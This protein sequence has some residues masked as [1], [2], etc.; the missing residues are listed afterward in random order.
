[1][2]RPI[3]DR[4]VMAT[5]L[6]P[7]WDQ[8]VGCGGELRKLGC[9]GVI[10][11]YVITPNFFGGSG[12]T[13]LP[14]A[15]SRLA[16]QRRVLE[17]KGLEVIIETPIGLPG[18][19]VNGVAQKYGAS[20]IIIGSHG[21]SRWREGVL[22]TFSSAVLHNVRFPLLILP[23]RVVEGHEPS[24]LWES[25]AL[26]SHLLFPTDFSQTAAEAMCYLE[27][28]APRG[29]SRVTLLHALM[30]TPGQ[31]GGAH[32]DAEA[33]AMARNFLDLLQGRLEAAGVPQV[34]TRV[35]V[36]HPVA[37]IV[38]LLKTMDISLIVL[39]TQ[40]KGF[41]AEIS[42]GSVAHNISRFAPCPLLLIPP[43]ELDRGE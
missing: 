11:T 19:S 28:L 17:E 39:G 16:A 5:D 42:L 26:L 13:L 8:I 29:V 41:I 27:L 21:K 23:V 10:L 15:A 32:G 9:S 38:D 2:M 36:G 4:V 34:Q 3:F 7:A 12:E 31:A 43:A 35:A 1:M 30:A 40:G 22:G 6:T 20:L 24:C 33:R 37:V 14:P 18:R 25:A